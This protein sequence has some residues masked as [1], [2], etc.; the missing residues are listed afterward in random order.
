MVSKSAI[1]RNICVHPI[2]GRKSTYGYDPSLAAGIVFC[3][4]FGLSMLLHTFASIRYRT[5]WQLVFS[6]GAL[7]EVLG[8]AGRAWSHSCP[9]QTTPYLLQ[10]CTLIIGK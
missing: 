5:W 7:C 9:Y 1:N 6:I 3:A 8:W 2:P 10:I 4:L